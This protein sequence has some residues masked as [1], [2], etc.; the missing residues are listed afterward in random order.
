MRHPVAVF[1]PIAFVLFL[2]SGLPAMAGPLEDGAAAHARHDYAQ[3]LTSF[4]E[5]ADQGS[6]LAEDALGMMYDKGEGVER[7]SV[8]SFVW[9][10]KAAEAG[11]ASG[12]YY[13]AVAYDEGRGVA[14]SYSTAA[15]WFR[16]AADQGN[17]DAEASLANYYAL[18]FGV[19]KDYALAESWARK[20]VAGG[21]RGADEMLS[22]IT[23]LEAAKKEQLAAKNTQTA[24][25]R[26]AAPDASGL[27][28]MMCQMAIG[29]SD[30]PS[31]LTE[32]E[33]AR[34]IDNCTR[35]E[36]AKANTKV[37]DGLKARDDKIR[38]KY[39]NENPH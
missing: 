30:T 38:Q 10:R 14:Q 9:F 20:A 23:K 33:K 7:D 25:A 19:P 12:Q 2:G 31:S 6:P 17:A 39:L 5:A 15:E 28:R 22:L 32:E 1:C 34:A 18:G 3:A 35:I 26:Q 37:H 21:C 16:K 13:V 36:A 11:D 8:A 24:Q 29:G 27:A 4:R